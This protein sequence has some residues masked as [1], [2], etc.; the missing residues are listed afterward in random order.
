MLERRR[1]CVDYRIGVGTGTDVCEHHT[2]DIVGNARNARQVGAAFGQVFDDD[3]GGGFEQAIRKRRVEHALIGD[4]AAVWTNATPTVS[5]RSAAM[6]RAMRRDFD[7]RVRE[8]SR[9]RLCG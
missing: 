7:L 6:S 8:A 1:E 2:D 5:S 4:V 3:L 9:S